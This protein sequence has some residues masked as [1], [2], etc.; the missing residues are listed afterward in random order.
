MYLKKTSWKNKLDKPDDGVVGSVYH[1]DLEIKLTIPSWESPDLFKHKDE[2]NKSPKGEKGW[3]QKHQD[4]PFQ[5]II[6]SSTVHVF[7]DPCNFSF[8]FSVG[9]PQ[10]V[11][12]NSFHY[13]LP[14]TSTFLVGTRL[15]IP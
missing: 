12:S 2:A 5:V 14:A 6:I 9:Q 11:G 10:A 15:S 3:R 8:M 4:R 1:Q 13:L 7:I